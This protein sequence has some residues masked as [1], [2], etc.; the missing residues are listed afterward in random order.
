M[1]DL[2]TCRADPD[3]FNRATLLMYRES[4][5]HCGKRL[6]QRH[7]A[8]AVVQNPAAQ[9]LTTAELDRLHEL[10]FAQTP[11]PCYREPIPA[12]NSIQG[13]ITVNRG[14]SGGCSF[15]ALTIHRERAA[16]G[17]QDGG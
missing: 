13:S 8:R 2:A 15:C 14:C 6:V 1:P 10:P 9:P 16:R 4:N 5:P 12:L 3:A 11:H 17:A 7:G